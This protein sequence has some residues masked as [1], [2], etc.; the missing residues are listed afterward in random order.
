MRTG[1]LAPLLLLTL[2]VLPWTGCIGVETTIEGDGDG[3]PELREAIE[4]WRAERLERLTAPDGWLTL[5]GLHW[6]EPGANR[7]GSAPDADLPLPEKAPAALGT[8][9]REGRSLSFTA[10]P[11]ASV[12]HEGEPVEALELR[13]DADGEP[14]ELAAAS[15]RFYVIERGGRLALRVKD[16]E[17]P[18]R[19]AFPGLEYFPID[20]A[21][22]LT[23][24]FEPYEPPRPISIVNVLDMVEEVP[25]PGALVFT[26]DGA[27]HRLDALPGGEEE[28]FLIFADETSGRSTYGAG[29]YLYTE[30]PG[31][32][33]TVTIDF[34]RAYNPPCAFTDHA[35]CPL[36]P[37]GNRLPIAV[38]AG[39]R[40]SPALHYRPEESHRGETSSR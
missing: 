29:R 8:I 3:E 9:H 36:P 5:V 37:P 35:T 19:D 31:P 1:R 30:R 32:D 28:L 7:L 33:G 21:W 12:L 39:E 14:T 16:T 20:P 23:A 38:E 25:S 17:H 24:R 6:I 10:A 26:V 27:S 40:Y 22:R 34:N 13:S 18:A 11:G 2:A 4:R 15:L